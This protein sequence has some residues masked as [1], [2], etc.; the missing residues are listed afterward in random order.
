MWSK[1]KRKPLKSVMIRVEIDHQPYPH[2]SDER[3]RTY[4]GPLTEIITSYFSQPV[5]SYDYVAKSGMLSHIEMV[6]FGGKKVADHDKTRHAAIVKILRKAKAFFASLGINCTIIHVL[7]T[8]MSLTDY[9]VMRTL[10][11][12]RDKEERSG[13]PRSILP[14]TESGLSIVCPFCGMKSELVGRG[15]YPASACRESDMPAN[16]E[17]T[18]EMSRELYADL[19]EHFP[20]RAEKVFDSPA[21]YMCKDHGD[22]SMSNANALVVFYTVFNHIERTA[23]FAYHVPR[24][25]ADGGRIDNIYGE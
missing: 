2:D 11:K 19:T 6:C 10:M 5:I 7:D 12:T 24:I 23:G 9:A 25:F 13:E 3:M 17:V 18:V 20:T 8:E 16:E 14:C 15:P 4:G 1:L 21:V 22:C